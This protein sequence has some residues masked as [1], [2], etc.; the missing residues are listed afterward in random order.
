MQ[1]AK[2]ITKDDLSLF[3]DFFFPTLFQQKIEKD[4]DIRVFYLD[5]I[6]YS[7]AI[8]NSRVDFREDYSNNRNV[9]IKL[10]KH[11]ELKIHKLNRNKII[12][13]FT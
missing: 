5:G 3:P 2:K 1:Y 6:C 13:Y 12:S 4:F 8:F 9:P 11:I 7:M 10:P